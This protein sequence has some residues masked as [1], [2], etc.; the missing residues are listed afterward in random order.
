[1]IQLQATQQQLHLA[2]HKATHDR[3]GTTMLAAPTHTNSCHGQ[4]EECG[5]YDDK[6]YFVVKPSEYTLSVTQVY[7]SARH[8]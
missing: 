3:P 4:D 1:M 2:M 8:S 6:G 7:S 5:G